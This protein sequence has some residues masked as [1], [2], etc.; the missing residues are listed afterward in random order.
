MT[1]MKHH[2][3]NKLKEKRFLLLIVPCNSLSSNVVR[4]RPQSGQQSE[5]RS[6][7]G[8]CLLDCLPWCAQ[9]LFL[10]NPVLLAQGR[11]HPQWTGLSL[12]NHYQIR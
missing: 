11:H 10:Q 5:S 3:Q 8:C 12:I 9:P 7:G 4:A 2:D 6:M 1:V